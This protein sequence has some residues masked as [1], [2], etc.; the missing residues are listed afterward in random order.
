MKNQRKSKRFIEKRRDESRQI[1]VTFVQQFSPARA[2]IGKMYDLSEN[3]VKVIVDK[4]NATP[5]LD[6]IPK[7][8]L[9]KF[10]FSEKYKITVSITSIKRI[11]DVT[12]EDEKIGVVLNFE[13]MSK[14]DMDTIREIIDIY[15]F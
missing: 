6:Y 10:R 8:T 1:T 11:D 4:K 7:T 5:L 13:V 9:T 14:D 2:F 15:S 12:T 3:A